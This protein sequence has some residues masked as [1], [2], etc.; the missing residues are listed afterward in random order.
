MRSIFKPQIRLYSAK[1]IIMLGCLLIISSCK[2]DAIPADQM[3]PVPFSQVKVIF[4]SYC[5][6][7]HDANGGGE[8]RYSFTDYE[9]IMQA[10]VPFNASKSKAYQSMTSTLQLMPPDGA[11]PTSQRTLIRLWIEQGAKP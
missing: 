1:L 11:V 10:I 2:H 9:G 6:K 4:T 8:S 7:C 5:A 3:T